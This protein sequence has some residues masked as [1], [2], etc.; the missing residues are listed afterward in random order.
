[1]EIT[2]ED[3]NFKANLLPLCEKCHRKVRKLWGE[4]KSVKARV[5][6]CCKTNIINFQSKRC[7]YCSVYITELIRKKNYSKT[8]IKKLKN[9]L[10]EL[11]KSKGRIIEINSIGGAI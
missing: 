1:M 6:E 9:K 7:C 3:F 8:K 10:F 4:K 11:K 2:K 5:C